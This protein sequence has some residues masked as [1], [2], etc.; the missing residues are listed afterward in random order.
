MP[1]GRNE[2]FAWLLEVVERE[3]RE[4]VP[5][6]W[7]GAFDA[8]LASADGVIVAASDP[9]AASSLA[10]TLGAVRAFFGDDWATGDVAL[11]NDVY[12]GCPHATSFTAV[13]PLGGEN[14]WLVLRAEFPD[15]GGWDLGGYT[16]RALDI[17]GEGARIVPVKLCR[18][19]AMRGEILEVLGLNS[20]TPRLTRTCARALVAAAD[21]ARREASALTVSDATEKIAHDDRRLVLRLGSLGTG[22]AL[23][24][25]K[26]P[27][28]GTAGE[29]VE[30]AASLEWDGAVVRASFPDAPPPSERAINTTVAMA[31]DSVCRAIASHLG[32]DEGETV[33][34]HRHIAV[35][36][37]ARSLLDA[38]GA[39]PVGYAQFATCAA[40]A[41]AASAALPRPGRRLEPAAAAVPSSID[42][43]SGTLSRNR[44]ERLLALERRL[45]DRA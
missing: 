30:I 20:R 42:F 10:A 21:A 40:I 32:L 9:G 23:G 27:I 18:A 36:I 2:P 37:P 29:M 11:T 12:I 25:G 26:A 13:A 4:R 33:A 15:I 1:S 14:R 38:T 45:G 16:R 24:N 28:P 6:E 34:L 41:M 22:R 19:G 44:Q 35:D 43:A 39:A 7:D 8:A 17:W 3:Y 5:R 31:R